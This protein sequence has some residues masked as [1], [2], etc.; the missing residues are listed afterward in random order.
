MIGYYTDKE[1]AAL[2]RITVPRLRNKLNDGCPLP[3]RIKPP[4][5]RHRLWP[6]EQVH[7]WLNQYLEIEDG[8]NMSKGGYL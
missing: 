1:I 5:C 6:K 8:L 2:L 7:Q 3:P 4:A